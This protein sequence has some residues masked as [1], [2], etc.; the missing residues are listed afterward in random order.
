MPPENKEGSMFIDLPGMRGD[1]IYYTNSNIGWTFT[2]FIPETFITAELGVLKKTYVMSAGILLFIGV[3]LSLCFALR[4]SRHLIPLFNILG[5]TNKNISLSHLRN[6]VEIT[7]SDLKKSNQFLREER[8]K[9][10]SVVS[11][12]YIWKLL[13]GVIDKDDLFGAEMNSLVPKGTTFIAA[14]MKHTK[15][16]EAPEIRRILRLISHPC[17]S[18]IIRTGKKS[19]GFLFVNDQGLTDF[20]ETINSHITIIHHYLKTSGFPDSFIAPGDEVDAVEMI[21]VSY[22]T[23][24]KKLEGGCFQGEDISSAGEMYFYPLDIENKLI[25]L[26][27]A[28]Q[29]E[30]LKDLVEDIYRQNY[31]QRLIPPRETIR[32]FNAFDVTMNRLN[33]I[34]NIPKLE[35]RTDDL[36]PKSY[37]D[38]LLNHFHTICIH[39]EKIKKSHNTELINR[40]IRFI[41]NNYT[42]INFS[43]QMVADEFGISVRYCSDF[44]LEQTGENF[45]GFVE[46]LRM[47]KIQELMVKEKDDI[48]LSQIGRE[49]GYYNVN[50]FYKAFKRKFG[51]SP[52]VFRSKNT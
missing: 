1:L 39:M 34:P 19:F 46:N 51:V 25:N 12:F 23:A 26:I 5:S 10:K 16:D 9:L 48:A 11:S 45:T 29:W 35:I 47:T 22:R 36:N 27:R 40:M 30:S 50:T 41:Q 37:F 17:G 32:L 4:N 18:Y 43:L 49:A 28:G 38:D 8:N 7:L 33:S 21:S 3:V 52:S 20:S 2:R 44:F 6:L 15:A 14:A 42:D 31:I 13:E 24:V